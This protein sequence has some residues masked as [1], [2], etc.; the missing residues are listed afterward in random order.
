MHSFNYP[1][2]EKTRKTLLWS[3][4]LKF[5]VRNILHTNTSASVKHFLEECIVFTIFLPRTTERL[6]LGESIRKPFF[7]IF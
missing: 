7:E 6:C 3:A 5:N 2:A 1:V 4:Y